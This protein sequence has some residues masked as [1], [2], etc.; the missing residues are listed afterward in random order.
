MVPG[1]VG[2]AFQGQAA[3]NLDLIISFLCGCDYWKKEHLSFGEWGTF[4]ATGRAIHNL[5]V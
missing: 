2:P 4:L 1:G 5:H 3:P